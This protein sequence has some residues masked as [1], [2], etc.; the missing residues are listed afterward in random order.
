MGSPVPHWRERPALWDVLY[1]SNVIAPGIVEDIDPGRGYKIDKRDGQGVSQPT[2]VFKGK[3]L[4]TITITL[5]MWSAR[6]LKRAGQLLESIYERKTKGQPFDMSHPILQL[7]GF[8][9]MTVEDTKGPGMPDENDIVRMTLM[10]LPW[11]PPFRPA[12]GV[13][14]PKL[15]SP[16]FPSVADIA[17]EDALLAGLKADRRFAILKGSMTPAQLSA[18]SE[19][20]SN[21]EARAAARPIGPPPPPK[22][23]GKLKP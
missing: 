23:P 16:V 3:K 15:S 20:I 22:V 1:I 19:R 4:P 12:T 17:E 7:H 5:K 11:A 2:Q 8:R 6:H 14:T 13:S 10:C 18:M 21:L 9:S